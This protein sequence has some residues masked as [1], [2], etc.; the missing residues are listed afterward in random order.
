MANAGTFFIICNDCDNSRFQKYENPQ[1]YLTDPA[2]DYELINQIALKNILSAIYKHEVEAEMI[3]LM[4]QDEPSTDYLF[5]QQFHMKEIE[6]QEC[7]NAFN[8]CQ[9]STKSRTPWLNVIISENLNYIAPIAYQGMIPV[10]TGFDGEIINN[11]YITD[12]EYQIEYIH[13]AVLPINNQTIILAF[14]D[15]DNMRYDRFIKRVNALSKTKKV[16]L[17][18]YMLFLYCEEYYYSKQITQR[19]P[20]QV[21]KIATSLEDPFF[22]NPQESLKRA[23]EDYSLRKA[24]TFPNVLGIHVEGYL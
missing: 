6:I 22:V 19:I 9:H 13:F 24:W 3:S 8:K 7:Y 23:I 14:M 5:T 2:R 16:Q 20:I 18:S 10:I 15:K 21:K 17:I 4:Q 12:P 1:S 11:K